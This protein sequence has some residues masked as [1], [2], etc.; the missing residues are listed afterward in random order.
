MPATSRTLKVRRLGRVPAVDLDRQARSRLLLA[1]NGQRVGWLIDFAMAGVLASSRQRTPEALSAWRREARDVLPAFLPVR[2]DDSAEKNLLRLLCLANPDQS[3]DP[4][5]AS[6]ACVELADWAATTGRP[7]T[8]IAWRECA[9][10]AVP[11]D[12]E[13]ARLAGVAARDGSR[14][15]RARQW[16]VRAIALASQREEWAVCARCWLS[17]ATMY[18]A[19][20]SLPRGRRALRRAAARAKMSGLREVRGMVAHDRFVL[21]TKAGRSRAAERLAHAA[22]RLY[23]SEQEHHLVPR[24]GHDVAYWWMQMGRFGEALAVL[25]HLEPHFKDPEKLLRL[26]A[27]RARA[28]AATGMFDEFWTASGESLRQIGHV[29]AQYPLGE[30]YL[31]LARGACSVGA[32]RNALEWAEA[33]A[34]VAEQRGL[35][36]LAYEADLVRESARQRYRRD[37]YPSTTDGRHARRARPGALVADMA[38][39]LT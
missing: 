7:E 5:G 15:Q 11:G 8:A 2:L 21:E 17:V 39:A 38:H 12:P 4:D 10:H 13:R 3:I 35:A 23:G 20:G 37:G 9:A 33:S 19:R 29:K 31:E 26:H 30:A 14:F 32:W 36:K 18:M 28:Y 16:F 24:L 22:L 27:S 25:N 34:A 1:E 6:L